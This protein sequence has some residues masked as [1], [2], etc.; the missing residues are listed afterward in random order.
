MSDLL[1][2][3]Q[4]VEWVDRDSFICFVED[5]RAWM[6]YNIKIQ[7]QG[8]GLH[9]YIQNNAYSVHITSSTRYGESTGSTYLFY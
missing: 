8:K 4:F 6:I 7:N 2:G 1:G 9:I 3:N 5:L